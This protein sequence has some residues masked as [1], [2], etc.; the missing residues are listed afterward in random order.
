MLRNAGHKRSRP[1]VHL[2]FF[3]KFILIAVVLLTANI[4][5]EMKADELDSGI[6]ED[7]ASKFFYESV[8]NVVNEAADK[9]SEFQSLRED[10]VLLNA[11]ETIRFKSYLEEEI[12]EKLN[13]EAALWIPVGSLTQFRILN[14]AGFKVPVRFFFSS[15]VSVTIDDR[16]ESFGINEN[17]SSMHATVKAKMHP[18]RAGWND[19]YTFESSYIIYRREYSGEMPAYYVGR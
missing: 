12:S 16:C 3:G 7:C 1:R 13:G 6:M 4:Y 9:A 19:E 17:V 11:A 10:T 2:T 14:G 5:I 18:V 8:T 15:S